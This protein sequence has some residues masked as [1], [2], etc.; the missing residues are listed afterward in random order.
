MVALGLEQKLV[1]VPLP[2]LR[3]EIAVL[4]RAAIEGLVA[5]QR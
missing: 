4:V 2:A 5:S 3:K 1:A